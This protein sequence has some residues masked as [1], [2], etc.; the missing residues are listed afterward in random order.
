M[1]IFTIRSNSSVNIM[2]RFWAGQLGFDS[3]QRHGFFSSPLCQD[4][5]WGPERSFTGV[6]QLVHEADDSPSS[7]AKVKNA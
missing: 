3:Q 4:W 1:T 2:T 6:K 5:L 7:S